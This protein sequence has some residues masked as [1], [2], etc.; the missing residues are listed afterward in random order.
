VAAS[1]QLVAHCERDVSGARR[2]VEI[3][4]PTGVADGVITAQT[5]YRAD[6]R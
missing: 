3:V 5:L 1:V 6:A 2:V 4:A